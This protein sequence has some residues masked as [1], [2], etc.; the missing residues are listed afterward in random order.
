MR[1]AGAELSVLLCGNAVNY[2]VAAQE[3]VGLEI[4]VWRQ[5]QPPRLPAD[6]AGLAAKGVEVYAVSEDLGERGIAASS[7]VPE[8]GLVSRAQ[9][10]ALF[11]KFARI[12]HW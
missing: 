3:P 4:G 12:W 1:N 8:V 10:P 2:A 9:L 11:A 7:L 6:V 5:A